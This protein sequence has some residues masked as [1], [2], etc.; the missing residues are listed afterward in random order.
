MRQVRWY[1]QARTP[2]GTWVTREDVTYTGWFYSSG[3]DEPTEG[4]LQDYREAVATQDWLEWRLVQ[5]TRS[6]DTK[7]V[8]SDFQTTENTD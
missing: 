7:V 2:G 4:L 6:I 8:L 5:E 1:V 3:A